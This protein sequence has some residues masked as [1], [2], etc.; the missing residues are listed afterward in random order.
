MRFF[1]LAF[2][3]F[4]LQRKGHCCTR[5]AVLGKKQWCGLSQVGPSRLQVCVSCQE[6]RMSG[7]SRI[8]TVLAL[9]VLAGGYLALKHHVNL[10]TAT[11]P[12][13][14]PLDQAQSEVD[15]LHRDL[16]GVIW[17]GTSVYRRLD[18]HRGGGHP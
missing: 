15:G 9:L 18:R 1:S 5:F 8:A 10:A 13:A 3:L 6:P 17:A 12:A 7:G 11:W 14:I 4:A 16:S 2:S